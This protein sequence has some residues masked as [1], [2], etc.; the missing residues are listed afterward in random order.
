MYNDE[1]YKKSWD[2][3]LLSCVS[4]EDIPKILIE[5][6][7]GWYGSHIGRTTHSHVTGETPFNLVYGSEAGLPTYYQLGFNKG[8]N[9]QRMKEQL[10][11]VD[12]LRD[13]ALYKM[14]KYKL[15][16]ARAYNLRV[17]NKKFQIGE[18]VLRLYSITHSKDKDKL[19]HKC[20]GPYRIS[21]ILGSGTYKL[22]RMNG[23]AI[24]HIRHASNLVK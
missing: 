11:L 13:R 8:E 16:M 3:P 5:V 15:I 18:L 10:N 20:E 6:H 4:Q 1:L 24:P 2:G 14:K 22:E 17:K 23:D 9:N 12:E 21:R 19:S 7:Q